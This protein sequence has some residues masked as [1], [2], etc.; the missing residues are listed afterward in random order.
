[1]RTKNAKR[2][3]PMPATLTVVALAAFLAFGLMAITG[4]QP[5]AAQDA[6]DC[7]VTLTAQGAAAVVDKTVSDDTDTCKALGDT[8]TVKFTGPEPEDLN[9]VDEAP[10]IQVLIRDNSGAILAYLDGHVVYDT[11]DVDAQDNP[12]SNR[13]ELTDDGA[14][15]LGGSAEAGDAA[16]APMKFRY[17]E[18]EVPWPARDPVSLNVE[19]QSITISVTGNVYIYSANADTITD[20]IGIPP[21]VTDKR[22][23]LADQ[24]SDVIITFL[25]EPSLTRPDTEDCDNDNNPNTPADCTLNGQDSNMDGYVDAD[26]KADRSSYLYVELANLD[27]TEEAAAV[28]DDYGFDSDSPFQIGSTTQLLAVAIIKDAKGQPLTDVGGSKAKGRV[29]FTISYA[30]GSDLDSNPITPQTQ[31]V[32]MN[33]KAMVL[34]DNWEE[35]GDAAQATVTAMYTGPTGNLDLG[36]VMVTR[37]GDPTG[38]KAA[39]FSMGCLVDPEDDAGKDSDADGYADDKFVMKD[40]ED[41]VMDARFGEGQAVV[42]KAHLEDKLMS[43]VSGDLSVSLNN[44]GED[45][46]DTSTPVPL[47]SANTPGDASVWVYTVGKDAKLGDHMIT[48]S[49]TAKDVDAQVLTVT[50]AG[51]PHT[52]MIDGPDN[53]ALNGE[54]MF[55]ITAQDV[56]QGTPHFKDMEARMLSVVTPGIDGSYVIGVTN[57]MVTL[58]D[59]TG[60]ETIIIYAPSGATNG[61]TAR[62]IVGTGDMQVIKTITFGAATPV[63]GEMVELMMP[64]GVRANPFLGL[65]NV[66]WTAGQGAHGHAVLLFNAADNAFVDGDFLNDPTVTDH[67]FKGVASGDYYVIVAAYQNKDEGGRDYEYDFLGTDVTVR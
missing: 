47:P 62:V 24:S 41:C 50:K 17:Q 1:M 39:I 19:A 28:G 34:L 53:I 40:N 27:G 26:S 14:E 33:G 8:A 48:V 43:M 23:E 42:V 32:D 21:D 3:W 22:R 25:G 5:A 52:L 61:Q 20:S 12:A 30:A 67:T 44:K 6:A 7:E 45:Q 9:N 15:A 54:A 18:I 4:A 51:P 35:N 60:M 10:K 29:T 38:L 2:L 63:E 56:G 46:L 37:G 64:T 49:T 65:V 11:V 59:D 55:T 66:E 31:G 36:N 57:N 16:P 13:Y 58:D